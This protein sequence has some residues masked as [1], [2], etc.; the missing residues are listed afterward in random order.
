MKKVLLLGDSIRLNYMPMVCR[1]LDGRADVSGPADNCRFAKYTLFYI[2][3]WLSTFGKPDIIHWN[4]GLWDVSHSGRDGNLSPMA[5]YVSDIMRV[6]AELKKTGAKIIFATSTP[7][8]EGN[9]TFDN[10]SIR[11][12]NAAVVPL[13]RDQGVEINDLHA[14][15]TPN[16]GEF[17]CDDLTHLSKEGIKAVGGRVAGVIEKYL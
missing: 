8:K 2:P 3:E 15:V 5:H 6:F 12:Y 4:N 14:F 7:V 10:Q 17:I 9:P 11:A 16:A 13:L 1:V